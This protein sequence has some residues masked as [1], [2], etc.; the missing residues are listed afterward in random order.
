MKR[1]RFRLAQVLRVRRL[2]EDQARFA[3][4]DANRQA[5]AAAARL[6]A[7]IATYR[8]RALPIGAQSYDDFE[9][10]LFLLDSAAA[11]VVIAREE[12]RVALETVEERREVWMG[13]R[14]RVAA[15]ER[16][17]SRRRDEHELEMRREEDR[18][19]DDLVVARHGRGALA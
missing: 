11:A 7:G 1:F 16:L 3:L 17:E 19:V 12:H 10:N 14:Q 18:L 2:Q 8:Q 6:E 9:R 15:L 4:L 13:A 5:H